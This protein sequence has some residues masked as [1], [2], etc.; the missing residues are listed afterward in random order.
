M[1]ESLLN[2]SLLAS[3]DDED[4]S[5]STKVSVAKFTGQSFLLLS[6][7][8]GLMVLV[9]VISNAIVILV[10][11][12]DKRLWTS[13]NLF[14][15]NLAICD[16]IVGI[17]LVPLYVP[18][19]LTGRWAFGKDICKLWLTISCTNSVASVYT[20]VLISYDRFHSVT[21]AV[22]F[23]AEQKN[24][25][26][27][28]LKIAVLWALSFLLYSPAIIL[29]D[30][31]VG[32]SVVLNGKCYPE[33]F[34]V[35]EFMLI[36]SVFDFVTPLL[37]ILFF[38]IRIYWNIMKRER[39]RMAM[40][41]QGSSK[42]LS[43]NVGSVSFVETGKSS[44]NTQ[45]HLSSEEVRDKST[46]TGRDKI[47]RGIKKAVQSKVSKHSR[48]AIKMAQQRKTGTYQND[49]TG[50]KL[51]KDKKVVKALATIVSVF[52]I[53]WTPSPILIFIQAACSSL[54]IHPIWNVIASW[55][56]WIN[57]LINPVL[58]PLCHSHFRKALTKLLCCRANTPPL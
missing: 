5:N 29:W 42:S 1:N 54:Y 25:Y 34:S 58:Y 51:S 10:F 9:T 4:S 24:V 3:D 52:I 38:N 32:K 56:L 11:I 2:Y 7:L 12:I 50:L 44:P 14:F 35:S 18:Y 41:S 16:F 45:T 53:C 48:S 55:A 19:V 6:F 21:K 57:S 36:C 15:L 8:A 17:L 20:V 28:S 31:I 49:A 26:Y 43:D 46:L 13:S 30:I 47:S 37:C 40:L 33:F 23:R 22:S 39:N 27:A